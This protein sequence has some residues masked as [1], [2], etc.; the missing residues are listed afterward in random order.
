MRSTLWLGL[1]L[2]L[3]ACSEEEREPEVGQ[4]VATLSNTSMGLSTSAGSVDVMFAPGVFAVG[5]G[6]MFVVGQAAPHELEILAEDG[7]NQPMLDAVLRMHTVDR[8]IFGADD[9]SVGYREAPI[10]PGAQVQF[11]FD[12]TEGATLWFASMFIQSN[13]SFIGAAGIDPFAI[14]PNAG[15]FGDATSEVLLFD[16][17]TEVDQE[18]GVG[19]DQAPRQPMPDTGPAEDGVIAR[20]DGSDDGFTYP[21]MGDVLRLSIARVH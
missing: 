7:K 21:S 15:D 3:S 18:P 10:R 4:F 20:I 2:A 16:A 1:A 11:Q 6:P 14:A 9:P 12:A 17:G 13:D 8:G 19:G 5:D